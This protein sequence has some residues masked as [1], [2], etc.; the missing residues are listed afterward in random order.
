VKTLHEK[1][2]VVDG[3]TAA[4]QQQISSKSARMEKKSR[5]NVA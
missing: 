3:S 4:V 1:R 5:E 2:T